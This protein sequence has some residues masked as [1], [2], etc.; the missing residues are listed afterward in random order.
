MKKIVIVVGMVLLSLCSLAAMKHEP[1]LSLRNELLQ[2]ALNG[3]DELFDRLNR[4]Y[5]TL[6]RD[7]CLPRESILFDLVEQEN[8]DN[9]KTGIKFF[10]LKNLHFIDRASNRPGHPRNEELPT[11]DDM[12]QDMV[13]DS[14]F[15]V[16]DYILHVQG[17]CVGSEN[18]NSRATR[19]IFQYAVR[20][21]APKLLRHLLEHPGVID[22][23]AKEQSL[24]MKVFIDMHKQYHE[25]TLPAQISEILHILLEYDF[26]VDE[27]PGDFLW[28]FLW[29]LEHIEITFLKLLLANKKFIK[30]FGRTS[31]AAFDGSW[32]DDQK[33][34]LRWLA[35]AKTNFCTMFEDIVKSGSQQLLNILLT[36]KELLDRMRDENVDA[37][38]RYVLVHRNLG[39]LKIIKQ[40]EFMKEKAPELELVWPALPCQL[41]AANRD[42]EAP[43][44]FDQNAFRQGDTH[45]LNFVENSQVPAIQEYLSGYDVPEVFKGA[46]VSECFDVV[47]LIL[48]YSSSGNFQQE[49]VCTYGIRVVLG[50]AVQNGAVNILKYCLKRLE[51]VEYLKRHPK[52]L[53][54]IADFLRKKYYQND[55]DYDLSG[56][57]KV[58]FDHEFFIQN[59]SND[60]I[61]PWLLGIEVQDEAFE[62]IL[63][64]KSYLKKLGLRDGQPSSTLWHWLCR[65][66]HLGTVMDDLAKRQSEKSFELFEMIL[67]NFSELF[68]E[69]VRFD[70]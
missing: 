25:G 20:Y 10:I 59:L 23:L 26:F 33:R 17:P 46:H 54:Q 68:G 35:S 24:L 51:I 41:S 2:A 6:F 55:P 61:W 3:D 12:V 4:E 7:D 47:D 14:C 58:L 57:I 8:L 40:N 38:V 18:V 56:M 52:I 15:D 66:T 63:T 13:Q 32:N 30:K 70:V 49:Y 50:Y 28:P 37:L 67:D 21:G 31:Y 43:S 48:H 16:I 1:G 65:G 9:L 69:A 34:M 11:L 53:Q 5:C 44:L 19:D 39:M 60:Y 29:G 62:N 64:K 22:V 36:D 45:I 27:M 42:L